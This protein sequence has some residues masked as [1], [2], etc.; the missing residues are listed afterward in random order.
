MHTLKGQY[1]VLKTFKPRILILTILMSE[2]YIFSITS[3][4]SLEH[5]FSLFRHKTNQIVKI[6]LYRLIPQNY[7]V[8][9]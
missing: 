8:Y 3:C 4:W 1:V 2:I 6:F 9:L 7:I 5:C